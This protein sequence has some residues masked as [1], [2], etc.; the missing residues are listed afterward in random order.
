MST[1]ATPD[2]T[3]Q[4]TPQP[5]TGT[6]AQTAQVQANT[7]TTTATV[8]HQDT[9]QRI[10]QLESDVVAKDAHIKELNKENEKYRLIKKATEGMGE[11][12]DAIK[13][14]IED[15]FAELEK[16]KA[17]GTPE[18]LTAKVERAAVADRLERDGILKESG[19]DP[20]KFSDLKGSDEWQIANREE[21]REGKKV[22]VAYAKVGDVEKPLTELVTE[23]FPEWV[24]SLKVVATSPV[25][26]AQSAPVAGAWIN[27]GMQPQQALNGQEPPKPAAYSM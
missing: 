24:D 16:F 27:Q 20:K 1:V 26:Q 12:P 7:P 23:K 18:E 11:T 10:A 14:A 13:K 2:A 25:Q 5:A 17:L 19:F 8:I 3:S 15:R 4:V 21:E 6:P 22:K 9:A